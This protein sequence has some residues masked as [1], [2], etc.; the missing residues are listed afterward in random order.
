MTKATSTGSEDVY[1][2]SASPLRGNLVMFQIDIT[3]IGWTGSLS[4]VRTTAGAPTKLPT[5]MTRIQDGLVIS[6]SLNTSGSYLVDLTGG[7]VFLRHVWNTGSV[8]I[9]STIVPD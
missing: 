1:L 7:D 5:V 2:G 3:S 4:P 8:D 6:G 9:Y